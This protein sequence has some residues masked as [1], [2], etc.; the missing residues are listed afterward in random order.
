LA[1]I[2]VT[3]TSLS[4]LGRPTRSIVLLVSAEPGTALW[5]AAVTRFALPFNP[6]LYAA[7]AAT[8]PPKLRRHPLY[9]LAARFAWGA[10]ARDILG[11]IGAAWHIGLQPLSETCGRAKGSSQLSR[12]RPLAHKQGAAMGAWAR[13]LSVSSS[14]HIGRSSEVGVCPQYIKRSSIQSKLRTTC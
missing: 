13:Y 4:T 9:W 2:A 5:P 8:V 6:A 11:V 12:P 10:R 14:C 1:T 7:E 3:M